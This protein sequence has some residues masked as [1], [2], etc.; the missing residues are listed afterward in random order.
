M[1]TEEMNKLIEMVI[2]LRPK[3]IEA[4]VIPD[5]VQMI[6]TYTTMVLTKKD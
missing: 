5:F 4:E 2:S 6:V 3:G 1:N